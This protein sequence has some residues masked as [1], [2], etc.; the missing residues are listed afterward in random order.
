M[1]KTRWP[2]PVTTVM[3]FLLAARP[4]SFSLVASSTPSARVARS[5]AKRSNNVLAASL[6]RTMRSGVGLPASGAGAVGLASG[7][8]R[9]ERRSATKL[10]LSSLSRRS[11]T[12]VLASS[13]SKRSVCSSFLV[14]SRTKT[15][16]ACSSGWRCQVIYA[17][18]KPTTARPPCKATALLVTTIPP[19]VAPPARSCVA[20]RGGEG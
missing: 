9:P 17:A 19:R 14:M 5:G 20:K 1:S 4:R 7:A 12:Q 8:A 6:P 13:S 10:P 2:A 11:S 3:C 18:T 15:S 16:P